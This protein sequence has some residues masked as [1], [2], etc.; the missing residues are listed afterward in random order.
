MVNDRIDGCR[1]HG[2]P[3]LHR[4]LSEAHRPVSVETVTIVGSVVELPV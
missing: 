3:A 4:R 2:E 1:E